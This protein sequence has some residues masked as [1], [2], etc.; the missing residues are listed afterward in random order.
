MPAPSSAAKASSTSASTSPGSSTPGSA[1][2]TPGAERSSPSA[3]PESRSSMTSEQSMALRLASIFSSEASPARE[4]APPATDRASTIQ[5]LLS[6][7]RWPESFAYYGPDSSSSRTWRTSSLSEEPVDRTDAYVAGLI[8]GEGSIYID[9]QY[10]TPKL[11]IGMTKAEGL[12]AELAERYG[13]KVRRQKRHEARADL[14]RWTVLGEALEP[15]LCRVGPHLR[16]KGEQAQLVLKVCEIRA[17]LP[18]RA[19][20]SRTWNP[21][22]KARVEK[23]RLRISALN[24]KGPTTTPAP[25]VGGVW[26]RAQT[27]LLA[28]SG[29]PFSG[30]WTRSGMCAHGTVYPLPPLAP[31]T[32]VTGSSSSPL[33]PTPR[34]DPRDATPRTPREDWRPSLGEALLPTP[35]AQQK[36]PSSKPGAKAQGGPALH[37][38]LL[39]TPVRQDGKNATAPS[40]AGRNSPPLTHVLL[41]TPTATTGGD[42][43]RPDGMRKLLEPEMRRLL[44]TPT[45]TPYGNN[46]SPSGGAAVRP[47]LE[48]LAAS[49]ATTKPPSNDGKKSP[50]PLLNPCFV[51]WMLGMPEG[52]SD[53][54][55]PLSATEFRCRLATSSAR[56]SSSSGEVA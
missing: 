46:Q 38:V 40:Q 17:E 27:S 4:E 53:P 24:R 48:S 10:L 49:G 14:F 16:L 11:E 12:L 51:E 30:S 44:P 19:N 3:G 1:S 35:L 55:C 20:G 18:A 2:Q 5:R 25:P 36:G 33:L 42:G 50:A 54:D 23:I 7:G 31:R 43:Q 32:S 37:H 52:W 13:G 8:D 9:R 34:Q 39:P 21:T 29:E 56:S 6:G 41:P 26:R 15:M 22:A 45:A 47:S 28:P